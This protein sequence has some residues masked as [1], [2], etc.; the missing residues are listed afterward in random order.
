M[1]LAHCSLCRRRK[2]KAF[3]SGVQTR[4]RF[5]D[6]VGCLVLFSR[7]VSML[8]PLFIVAVNARSIWPSTS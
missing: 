1:L 3:A 4:E 6:V 5:G 2:A 7:D 8:D